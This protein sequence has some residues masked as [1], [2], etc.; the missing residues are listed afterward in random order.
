MYI[1]NCTVIQNSLHRYLLAFLSE[2]TILSLNH[3][4]KFVDKDISKF[5]KS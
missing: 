5:H 4:C 3:A 1:L 2:A